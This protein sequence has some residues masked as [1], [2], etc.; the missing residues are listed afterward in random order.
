MSNIDFISLFCSEFQSVACSFCSKTYIL[1]F[2]LYIL[3]SAA[4]IL[5]STVYIICSVSY[6][7]CFT[8]YIICS[9]V[10]ILCSTAYI[11]C[12]VSYNLCSTAYIICYVSYFKHLCFISLKWRF[13]NKD[14]FMPFAC[15]CNITKT[16]SSM[17]VFFLPRRSI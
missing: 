4:Y 17:C 6:I 15:I 1:H 3:C 2:V 10:Y 14:S 16:I 11:I 13:S 12:Y 9:M 7:L 8:A 5:C